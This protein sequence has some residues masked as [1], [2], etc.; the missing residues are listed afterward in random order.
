MNRNQIFTTIEFIDDLIRMTIGEYY[1]DKFY[2]FDTFKCKC[3]G[4]DKTNI[5]DKEEV[6]RT[7]LELVKLIKDKT[8]IIVEELILCMPS[9][10]L[11]IENFTSTSPVNSKNFLISQYD[12]NEV[13]KSTSR[14]RHSDDRKIIAFAPLEYQLDDGQKLD[15]APIGYKSTTFK[16]L[17]NVFMLPIDV[18]DSYIDVIN[19]CDL[20]VDK[21]Y[22]DADCLYASVFE[23]DN[24]L[25]SILNV[26]K[27]SCSLYLYKKGKLLNKISLTYGTNIIEEE[28]EKTLQIND[29][30]ELKKMI[31][32]VGSCLES[33]NDY[34]SVC[35]N[36]ENRFISEKELN[37]II[38][39]C[40]R[41]L[42]ND[43]ISMA[44]KES[45]LTNLDVY[46]TGYGANIRGIDKLFSDI[47]GC[48]A[49]IYVSSILGL[50]NASY[51][52]TIGLIKLNYKKISQ[53]K[54]INLQNDN[55]NDIIVSRDKNSKF[56]KFILDEEEL[57]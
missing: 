24:I 4:L 54:Y 7:I 23:E 17:F 16:T 8:E 41:K 39:S 25:S 32:N 10:H 47:S 42:L 22:L 26:D 3:N 9:E 40:T 34:L 21:Y 29:Y 55:Y 49:S 45:T 56:D 15:I 18:F 20:K 13:Y 53:N 19:E 6:K 12:I 36:S 48:N 14:Y 35:Q 37:A 28:V 1:N 44:N 5:V 30:N 27:Y 11:I 51:C 50:N 2:V 33:S 57:D 46:I 31:Y 43:L 38:N 52:E